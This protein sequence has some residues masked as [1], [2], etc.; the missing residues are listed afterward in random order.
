MEATNAVATALILVVDDERD[1]RSTVAEMLELE[2]YDVD[3]A[4]NGA[5]ALDAV[6]RRTPDVILLDMRMPVL[7]GWGFAEELRHRGRKIPIVVMTAARD[8]GR[9][10][11]EIAATAA[12]SKPFG[13]D[14]LLRAVDR[15]RNAA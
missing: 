7:D 3:E 8:A 12:L 9:W 10:A 2:G 6:E 4:V 15:A 1:I 11:E 13:F 14:D 5:D